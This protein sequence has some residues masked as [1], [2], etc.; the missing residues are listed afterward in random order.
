MIDLISRL[1]TPEPE[2]F[3]LLQQFVH[4]AECWLCEYN[5]V[6]IFIWAEL[7]GTKTAIYNQ[8]L[9]IYSQ[10]N[11]VLLF[12]AGKPLTL[13][14]FLQIGKALQKNNQSGN[15]GLVPE[16][17]IQK[18][19]E[20]KDYYQIIADRKNADY[21]YDTV[22]LAELPGNRF[23][24]KKNLIRQFKKA[25]P[26]YQVLPLQQEDALECLRLA[27]IWCK[28]KDCQKENFYFELQALQKAFLMFSQL[29]LEGVKIIIENRI[30]AFALYSALNR[31]CADIHF[32]KF[33]PQL[34]GIAQLINQETAIVLRNTYRF[35][36]REQDL[37]LEG[38]RKA[39]LSYHPEK[40]ILP[41]FL[42]PKR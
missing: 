34:K 26:D 13:Q 39:K 2:Q 15:I 36:N 40:I 12:P 27:E 5:P 1:K 22:Q 30:Q 21:I 24:S 31:Q 18:N 23:H 42:K 16:A 38:L 29:Q 28:V 25:Y 6:N 37:G 10:L 8:R 11:D 9:F 35:I 41:F 17:F 19:P 4:Q 7:F 14:E 3:A 20:L 33:N 32:E